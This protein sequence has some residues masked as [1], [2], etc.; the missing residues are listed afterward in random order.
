MDE[1]QTD[2]KRI[3]EIKGVVCLALGAFLSLCLISYHPLDPSFTHFIS[4]G[5]NT[6]NFIGNFGSYTADSLIR[7]LG[8]G[9]F[10][11]PLALFICSFQYFLKPDFK[12]NAG[13]F[14]NFILLTI[15]FAGFLSLIIRNGIT[16]YGEQMRA[17]GFIGFHIVKLLLNFFNVAGTYII[18]LLILAIALIMITGLSLVSSFG[19]ST[20][21]IKALLLFCRS[22]FSDFYNFILNSVRRKSKTEPVIEEIS[23][24]PKKIKPRKVEQTHFEFTKTKS[25]SAFQLPPL[26]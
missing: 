6:H 7:L 25:D 15:A 23:P 20:E 11:L 12:I 26:T 8:A 14:F 24:V 4:E 16:I 1:K 2:N 17:G 22:R 5:R 18:L 13:H 19:R 3:R 10:L 21:F 9:S